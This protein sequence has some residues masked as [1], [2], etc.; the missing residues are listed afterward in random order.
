MDH[1]YC[2]DCEVDFDDEDELWDH[3][4]EDHDA[5]KECCLV[6]LRLPLTRRG[7]LRNKFQLFDSYSELE[8]HDHEVHDYCTK[9]ERGFQNQQSLQQH[10][11]SELHQPSNVVCPGQEESNSQW[12]CDDC[13]LDFE[14][15]DALTEH[16][17]QSQVHHYCEDCDRHFNLEESRR[18]HMDDKHWYCRE[19]D[20]VSILPTGIY[21]LLRQILAS[22]NVQV[23]ESEHG[24]HWHYKRSLD[25][26]YCFACEV[27]FDNEDELWDHSVEDHDACK[28]CHLV[29]LRLYPFHCAVC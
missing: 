19:H 25:H 5:C 26:H 1:H 8:E 13:D 20:Q 3:S 27:D 24:L 11:N 10:L 23:F 15:D 21:I 28:E 9:C 18:Q 17:I 14:S 16:Y 7:A 12:A 6:G 22:H 2:F 4:V 29:S